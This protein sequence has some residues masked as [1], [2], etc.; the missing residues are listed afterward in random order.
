MNFKKYR[1]QVISRGLDKQDAK[2]RQKEAYENKT[3]YTIRSVLGN[4]WATWFI[5]IGARQ[6]GKT[7][8]VQN[9]VLKDWFDPNSPVYH[10]PFYWM[11]LNDIAVK[12]MLMNNGAKM[13][14]P[15]LIEKY[16][17]EDIKVKGDTVYLGD[18]VLCRVYG[19]ST[20]HNNKGAAL[21]NSKNFT[22]CNIII[23]EVAF[24]KSQR[25]TF[26]VCYNLQMQ[27]E[28]LTRNKRKGVRI[29][30]MLNATE[31]CPD[32]IAGIAHFLPIEFGV[33]KLKRR[34]CIIDYIPNTEGYEKMRK[35][36]IAND[37]DTGNGNFTNKFVKDLSLLNK[38]RLT[39]PLYVVKYYK[40]QGSWYTVWEGNVICPYNEEKV[41]SVAM[42]R[43]IDDTFIPE[44]RD[45]IIEQEDVR[46]FKYK[47]L[48]T[49]SLWRKDMESIKK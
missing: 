36:A 30:V 27:I 17:L 12:N 15:L 40:D 18:A 22:G 5:L 34:N 37:I 41:R 42:K 14:E 38:K 9:K 23:D 47:D 20:A 39:K 49:Q 13:F 43:Y 3:W 35:E 16:H 10:K 4:T 1:K 48:L 32:V 44:W 33:Y 6:R 21:F 11:R 8:S 26:D 28:N 24:E 7:F 45:N 25:K 31:D 46:A 29:F 2:K 19:L